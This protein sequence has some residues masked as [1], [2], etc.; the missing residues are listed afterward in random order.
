MNKAPVD[1]IC[2]VVRDSFS[3]VFQETMEPVD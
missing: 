2:A 1:F 3:S